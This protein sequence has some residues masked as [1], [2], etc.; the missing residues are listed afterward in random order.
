MSSGLAYVSRQKQAGAGARLR[1]HARRSWSPR[2]NQARA[3]ASRPRA[4]CNGNRRHEDKEE[5]KEKLL[6]R[7][8]TATTATPDTPDRGWDTAHHAQS[9][10]LAML[11]ARPSNGR[12][13]QPSRYGV[14][15]PAESCG[16]TG[17]GPGRSLT[18]APAEAEVE[19]SA[20]VHVSPLRRSTSPTTGAVTLVRYSVFPEGYLSVRTVTSS[21][22]IRF[23]F[24]SSVAMAGVRVRE[25]ELSGAE[26]AG[27]VAAAPNPPH[28][29]LGLAIDLA[30]LAFERDP[31]RLADLGLGDTDLEHA[32]AVVGLHRAVFGPL[33]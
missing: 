2:V 20:T 6:R 26:A 4:S 27:R 24:A 1:R 5:D 11:S 33:R 12:G 28:A 19:T 17:V 3:R 32:V 16:M 21:D 22:D 29:A 18:T 8:S 10:G 25:G 31:A 30:V 23:L 9:P 13:G 7:V 14:F 15:A